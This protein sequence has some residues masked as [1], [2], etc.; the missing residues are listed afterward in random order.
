MAILR[1]LPIPYTFYL[2]LHSYNLVDRVFK[3]TSFR[4]YYTL[5]TDPFF[6]NAVQRTVLFTILSVSIS[7][8]IALGL[9]LLLDKELKGKS[10]LQGIFLFPMFIAHVAVGTIWYIMFT[11]IISPVNYFLT[12]LGMSP[13]LWLSKPT[14]AFLSIVISDIWQWTPFAFILLYAGLQTINPT[15]YEAAKIDGASSFQIF[16]GITL[17]LMLGTIVIAAILRFMDS[18]RVFAKIYVM[19]G[20][21]PG[22]STETVSML[23]YKRA[24]IFFE[25]GESSAMVLVLLAGLSTFYL[26]AMRV[27]SPNRKK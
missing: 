18:F 14:T 13:V 4:N 2:S 1:W 8:I 11:P 24:F 6:I 9:A 7:M 22:R 16:R 3:F 12:L 26:I 15:L 17:P 27:L 21:G 5:I 20:G 25:L 10:L 19:T 23:I